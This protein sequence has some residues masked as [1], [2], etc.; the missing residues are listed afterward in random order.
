R[1]MFRDAQGR[2]TV[3]N[4]VVYVDRPLAMAGR[5]FRGISAE[6]HPPRLA[7]EIRDIGDSPSLDG[8]LVLHKVLL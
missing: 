1:V 2:E 8:E 7:K 6:P 5:I 3:S 4:A